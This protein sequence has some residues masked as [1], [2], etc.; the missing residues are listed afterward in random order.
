MNERLRLEALLEG[1][2]NHIF[3]GLDKFNE[4]SREKEVLKEQEREMEINENYTYKVT[5]KKHEFVKLSSNLKALNCQKCFSTCHYPCDREEINCVVMNERGLSNATCN[6]CQCSWE[7]HMIK[8]YRYK[9]YEAKE[10]RTIRELKARYESASNR[11][12]KATDI[13]NRLEE[14]LSKIQR[15]IMIKIQQARECKQRLNEIALKPGKLTE[16]DYINILI[17]TEEKEKKDGYL[18]RIETLQ[19]VKKTAEMF[20]QLG[21]KSSQINKESTDKW[22]SAFHQKEQQIP[23]SKLQSEPI[24]RCKEV[25]DTTDSTENPPKFQVK[26]VPSQ[27][28]CM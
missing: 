7:D 17:L 23:K 1:L 4:I 15:D 11:V 10:T 18:E 3:N 27:L 22:W 14:D 2:Q 5:V 8:Q 21:E 20:V 9:S 19:K 6:V 28:L 25:Q 16:V 24:D 26:F 13:I 12:Q